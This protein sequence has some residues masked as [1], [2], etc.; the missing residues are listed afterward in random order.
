MNISSSHIRQII[1]TSS[2]LFFNIVIHPLLIP[3][4]AFTTWTNNGFIIRSWYPSMPTSF[5][6][7]SRQHN[8]PIG[9]VYVYLSFAK[10][11]NTAKNL[12]TIYVISL[13]LFLDYT[14][15]PVSNGTITIPI[16]LSSSGNVR[17]SG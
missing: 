1:L 15:L 16:M 4:W 8:I 3:I 10:K 17:V 13:F 7:I 14:M 5:T 12:Y 6:S 11:T 2:M 9:I